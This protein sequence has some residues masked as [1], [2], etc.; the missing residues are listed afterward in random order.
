MSCGCGRSAVCDVLDLVLSQRVARMRGADLPSTRIS[1][2]LPPRMAST[3]RRIRPYRKDVERSAPCSTD[4][5]DRAHR[6]V[7]LAARN[8]CAGPP[9]SPVYGCARADHERETAVH[10]RLTPV[11][12]ASRPAP[13][14]AP[15]T[16]ATSDHF[17][18]SRLRCGTTMS[19]KAVAS[20]AS[21]RRHPSARLRAVRRRSRRRSR[22][23][24]SP[25]WHSVHEQIPV[26]VYAKAQKHF[27]ASNQARP[28]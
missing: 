12:A 1:S 3:C 8:D 19:S 22:A 20:P 4:S 13:T 10:Q 23:W 9:H 21:H 6:F 7:A 24:P 17:H 2:S 11:R 27:V 25:S 18:Q 16:P 14:P 5:R 26:P 28:P 15:D